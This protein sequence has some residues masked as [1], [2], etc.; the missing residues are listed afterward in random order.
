MSLR[1]VFKKLNYRSAGQALARE[2]GYCMMI[3][4]EKEEPTSTIHVAQRVASAQLDQL[5]LNIHLRVVSIP[6]WDIFERQ[7]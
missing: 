6:A 1:G 5:C 4:G 3:G 2:R 7:T